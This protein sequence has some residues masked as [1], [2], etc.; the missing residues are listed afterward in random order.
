MYF[1]FFSSLKCINIADGSIKLE[2]LNV[3]VCDRKQNIFEVWLYGISS[4]EYSW[5]V[6]EDRSVYYHQRSGD[7][8]QCFCAKWTSNILILCTIPWDKMMTRVLMWRGLFGSSYHEFGFSRFNYVQ[9]VLRSWLPVDGRRVQ[10]CTN[11][12]GYT[13]LLCAIHKARFSD[14]LATWH[15]SR[16]IIYF[17]TFSLGYPAI[18]LQWTWSK[19]FI[20]WNKFVSSTYPHLGIW[21]GRSPS[22]ALTDFTVVHCV[23]SSIFLHKVNDRPL[24]VL[25]FVRQ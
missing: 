18:L 17:R 11:I 2:A 10:Q 15:T 16:T 4:F 3:K 22:S 1:L 20:F 7:P 23:P 9:V 21:N 25:K 12:H 19:Y 6:F 8:C 13:I 5:H 14:V 24:S